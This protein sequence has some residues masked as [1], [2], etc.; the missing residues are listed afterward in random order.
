MKCLALGAAILVVAASSF[1]FSFDVWLWSSAILLGIAALL[2][3]R[4]ASKR[5]PPPPRQPNL[6]G[7]SKFADERAMRNGGIITEKRS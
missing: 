5:R 3:Q 4:I 2:P 7:T 6:Y 1:Y